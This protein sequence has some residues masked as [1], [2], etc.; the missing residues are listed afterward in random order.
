MKE[1]L[2]V[3]LNV[4]SDYFKETQQNS[5]N[6]TPEMSEDMNFYLSLYELN[7]KYSQSIAYRD[8][9]STRRRAES[10]ADFEH[11]GITNF[12]FDNSER[13]LGRLSNCS[14]TVTAAYRMIAF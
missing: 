3:E 11:L 8:A 2:E 4:E 9:A 13:L 1:F 7:K 5:M 10:L 14:I 6:S 12:S